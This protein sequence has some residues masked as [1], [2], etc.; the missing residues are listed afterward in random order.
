MNGCVSTIVP[1]G[2]G[3]DEQDELACEAPSKNAIFNALH[4]PEL[5]LDMNHTIFVLISLPCK[6]KVNL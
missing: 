1:F 3:V 5:S 6:I 4:V 2:K